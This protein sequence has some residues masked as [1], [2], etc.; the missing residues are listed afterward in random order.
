MERNFIPYFNIQISESNT[1]STREKFGIFEKR[2][3]LV[4]FVIELEDSVY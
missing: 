2:K 1:L 4:K 3:L